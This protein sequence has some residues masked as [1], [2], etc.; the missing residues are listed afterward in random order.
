MTAGPAPVVCLTFDNG[1]TPGTTEAVLDVL[2]EHGVHATFFAIGRKVATASGRRLGQR[3]V[4]S[5]HQLG[6][7]TWTHSMQF[8]LADDDVVDN[9]LARTRL[10]V[11]AVGGN[12]LLFRPYGAGGVIDYRLMSTFGAST[13]RTL[14]YTCVLWNVL[15]GD[16]RDQDGWVDAALREIIKHQCSVVVLHD[17]ADASLDHLDEFLTGVEQLGGVWSQSFPDECTPIRD[18][19]PTSSFDTLCAAN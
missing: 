18:G 17:I 12:G 19:Q 16:W 13:L 3:I 10:A 1:P 6:G 11:D 4:E 2:A 7:H 14:G 9:E 5:G 15:P 8:G